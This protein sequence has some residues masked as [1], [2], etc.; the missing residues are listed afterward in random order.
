MH[1]DQMEIMRK[2][3]PVMTQSHRRHLIQNPV[4]CSHP[5][6]M[7]QSHRRH[8]IHNPVMCSHHPATQ[9][10]AM[11]GHPMG[12]MYNHRQEIMLSRL[13]GIMHKG[14]LVKMRNLHLVPIP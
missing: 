10:P 4:I 2:S 8:L 1:K 11:K 7:T 9:N 5:L 14:P 6:L 12:I 13:L 3:P